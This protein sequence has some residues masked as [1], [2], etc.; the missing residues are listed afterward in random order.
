[1][2]W[3]V[4][5]VRALR[6]IVVAGLLVG[7]LWAVLGSIGTTGHLWSWADGFSAPDSPSPASGMKLG[8]TVPR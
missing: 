5:W 3:N 1:M 6:T 7:L 8:T 4:S 2:S